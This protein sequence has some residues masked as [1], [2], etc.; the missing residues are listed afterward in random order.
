MIMG[1]GFWRLALKLSN[2]HI[3]T[4]SVAIAIAFQ[5]NSQCMG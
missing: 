1:T 5:K 2:T 3:D 4:D